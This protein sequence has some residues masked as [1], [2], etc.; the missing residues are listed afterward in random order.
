MQANSISRVL[1]LKQKHFFLM[2]NILM[3]LV[4]LTCDSMILWEAWLSQL[5]FAIKLVLLISLKVFLLLKI[6]KVSLIKAMDEKND[7]LGTVKN[8]T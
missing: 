2:A 3:S 6:K 8:G 1:S 4:L 7:N 5:T